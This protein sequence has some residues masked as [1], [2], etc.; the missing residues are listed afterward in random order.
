MTVYIFPEQN[1]QLF[2]E[3]Q[4]LSG[5]WFWIALVF[6]GTSLY[7]II[8]NR[9]FEEPHLVELLVNEPTYLL[10]GILDLVFLLLIY[11][12]KLITE[13]N[14]MEIKIRLIPFV[15]KR[16]RLSAIKKIELI[17]YGGVQ[18]W[19]VKHN[20][21]YGTIYSTR[22]TTG[23]Y[24]RLKNGEKFL[25]GTKKKYQLKKIIDLINVK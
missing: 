17:E 23:I 15:K 1:K 11:K 2:R 9:L 25:I 5:W 24:V 7:L 8:Y 22:P 20:T 3:S 18:G 12:M 14:Q 13:I 19:G 16:I 4:R 10:L 6:W 21:K